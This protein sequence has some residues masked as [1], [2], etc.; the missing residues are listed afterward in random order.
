MWPCIVTNLFLIK[1]TDA[2]ISQIHFCQETLHVSGSSSAHHQE[3]S[4]VHSTLVYVMQ[5]WWNLSITTRMVV[6]E[7]CHQTCMTY[8]SA[9]FTVENSW[10]WAEKLPETCRF[11]WQKWIWEISVSVGFIIKKYFFFCYSSCISLLRP[12]HPYHVHCVQNL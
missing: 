6:I 3:S 9:E 8:T 7:S 2:L 10:W 12:Q 1:P 4:T 5:V 11:S